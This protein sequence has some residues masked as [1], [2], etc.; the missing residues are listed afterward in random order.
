[1]Y[2]VHPDQIAP[3]E[4]SDLC[5]CSSFRAKLGS[6]FGHH[7]VCSL[8]LYLQLSST[9]ILAFANSLEPDQARQVVVPDLDPK[10]IGTLMESRKVLFGIV[11][12]EDEKSADDKLMSNT[13]MQKDSVA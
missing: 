13:S 2:S 4:K 9:A 8:T 10:L 3:R 5:I 7:P 12:F 6:I 11:H 1:M